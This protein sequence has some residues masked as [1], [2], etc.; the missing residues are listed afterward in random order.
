MEEDRSLWE[1][2]D[3]LEAALDFD[4]HFKKEFSDWELDHDINFVALGD[5]NYLR[6]QSN[7]C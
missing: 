7:G 5:G 2:I 1:E 3:M 6:R 4:S